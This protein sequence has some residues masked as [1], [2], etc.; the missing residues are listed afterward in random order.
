VFHKH[1]LSIKANISTLPGPAQSTFYATNRLGLAHYAGSGVSTIDTSSATHPKQ[2]QS[3]VYTMDRPGPNATLQDKPYPHGIVADPTGRYVVVLDRGAD[4]LRMYEIGQSGLLIDLGSY[5]VE[6]GN[7]PRH[8][9]FVQSPT[10]GKTW[11][12]A[13]GELTNSLFGF[14]VLYPE[15]SDEK[16]GFRKIYNASAYG[17]G[18]GDGYGVSLPAEIVSAEGGR[19]LVVSVRNDGRQTYAGEASDTIASYEVDFETGALSLVGLTASGGKWPRT[20]AITRDG[21]FIVSANQYTVP[22][23][24]VVFRRDPRTGRIFDKEALAE[25]A[26]VATLPDG[27]S[28]SRVLWDE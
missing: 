23:R 10:S 3:F 2:L 12:Y 28:I 20:I 21:R 24:V 18:F 15:G 25:W 11:F 7:G 9:V 22:G 8:G 1:D 5:E 4:L 13:L 27:Q 14:E 16:L 26:A 17:T 19:H 6:K